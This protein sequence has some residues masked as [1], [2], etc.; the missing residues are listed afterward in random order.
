MSCKFLRAL[1]TI[2]VTLALLTGLASHATAAA[3]KWEPTP[4][5][6]LS[7]PQSTLPKKATKAQK[8]QVTRFPDT[9]RAMV[10][11]ALPGTTVHITTYFTSY[12]GVVS[13][14]VKRHKKDRVNFRVVVR[15]ADY[16]ANKK[17][18]DRLRKLLGT[19]TSKRSWFK[20][21]TGSCY[22]HGKK[23]NA[24]MHL[25]V[26]AVDAIAT[27]S[28]TRR[29]VVLTSS[30]NLSKASATKT[31]NFSNLYVGRK[32]VYDA[33]VSYINGMR[34]DRTAKKKFAQVTEGRAKF[35]FSPKA[36][37]VAYDTLRQTKTCKP[38]KGYGQSGRTRIVVLMYIW[39][40]TQVKKARELTRLAKLGCVVD[41]IITGQ[42]TSEKII[43]YFKKNAKIT[44]TV[45]KGKKKVKR[46]YS[47]INLH[48]SRAGKRYSHVKAMAVSGRAGKKAKQHFTV[49]GSANWSKYALTKNCEVTEVHTSGTMNRAVLSAYD[50]I[51]RH[52][53]PLMVRQTLP[54]LR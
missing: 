2:V 18:L 48:D 46:S 51:R 50:V 40:G 14:V 34:H 47:L 3:K 43:K 28:G 13:D 53:K 16:R 17:N 24:E 26:V 5:P 39:T 49:V 12:K 31:W 37:D 25:K 32:K 4:G 23:D 27:P 20:V 42:Q 22:L 44:T 19:N 10:N 38:G 8:R 15:A 1:A 30:A 35:V 21:C 7:I 33:F 36:P 6:F 29:Y 9:V 41:I 11:A 54:K 52:T 45:K